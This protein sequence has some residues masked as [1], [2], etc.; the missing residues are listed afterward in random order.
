MEQENVKVVNKG[1]S[2]KTLI[3][4]IAILVVAVVGVVYGLSTGKVLKPADKILL[5]SY[6]T[7]DESIGV[8]RE[9][10]KLKDFDQKKVRMNYALNF[11]A[12]GQDM[13]YDLT[14][15]QDLDAKKLQ[16]Y[17][18]MN[19]A[20]IAIPNVYFSMNDEKIN[21]YA[22]DLFDAKFSYD[23]V[24][25]EVSDFVQ[26]LITSMESQGIP[27]EIVS[28]LDTTIAS[29]WDMA[30][31]S[32]ELYSKMWE[33]VKTELKSIE[34]KEV[35][36]KTTFNFDDNEIEAENYEFVVTSKNMKNILAGIDEVYAKYVDVE[37]AKAMLEKMGMSPL[38]I[39]QTLNPY[40]A[41]I[42]SPELENMK[43][44]SVNVY[45]A[46]NEL[47]GF[48]CSNEEGNV[49][50]LFGGKDINTNLIKMSVD[51]IET[52]KKEVIIK[53]SEEE[54]V[55]KTTL[56][57]GEG[58]GEFTYNTENGKFTVY[59]ES[60][61]QGVEGT[62]IVKKNEVSFTLDKIVS[63]GSETDA[64]DFTF[65]MD[66]EVE[67]IDEPEMT[68]YELKKLDEQQIQ[69]IKMIMFSVM[70]KYAK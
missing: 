35:A 47:I 51:G 59:E 5:A 15:N 4:I 55:I 45:L 10:E 26:S 64:F 65:S 29:Y 30:D 69:S 52:D 42:D 11:S 37:G 7:Y 24:N 57:A 22:P 41:M 19:I 48:K 14:F 63:D 31:Q 39:Q 32:Q 53:T 13:A 36:E 3:M 17:M 43:D 2:K 21:L 9:F 58:K 44:L 8:H 12:E 34:I 1:K 18:N 66:N 68:E 40:S 6:N 25:P 70:M 54:N 46:N 38:E 61:T 28:L 60:N 50:I 33:V 62:F 20:N 67:F 23:Y 49:E 27:A 16:G 56:D